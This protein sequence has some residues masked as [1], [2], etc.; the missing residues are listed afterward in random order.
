MLAPVLQNMTMFSL[1]WLA[2][3]IGSG[4]PSRKAMLSMVPPTQIPSTSPTILPKPAAAR[5]VIPNI[6]PRCASKKSPARIISA[7]SRKPKPINGIPLIIAN[8][9]SCRKVGFGICSIGM[10]SAASS[11]FDSSDKPFAGNAG[12]VAMIASRWGARSALLDSFFKVSTSTAFKAK[13]NCMRRSLSADISVRL[14]NA[15]IPCLNVI[16]IQG[17]EVAVVKS[18]IAL[19]IRTFTDEKSIELRRPAEPE[20]AGKLYFGKLFVTRWGIAAVHEL[21]VR[22][23]GR[24]LIQ[25]LEIVLKERKLSYLC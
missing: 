5:V 17:L 24:F 1:R 10:L 2:V 23:N 11:V 4:R 3:I 22:T 15:L 18:P 20:D 25:Y 19:T 12:S 14:V 7:L 16:G 8:R 21:L 9:C 6:V 13:R